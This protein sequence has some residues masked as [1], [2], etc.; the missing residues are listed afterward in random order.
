VR[1]D[2]GIDQDPQVAG[3]DHEPVDRQLE[4]AIGREEVRLEPA[5]V[6]SDG[7]GGRLGQ[8]AVERQ[9]RHHLRD[10]RDRH[11]ADRPAQ[12]RHWGSSR[13]RDARRVYMIDPVAQ[14]REIE[15]G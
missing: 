5:A 3:V 9:L 14:R 12:Q 10:A 6:S 8:E 13:A 4:L 15:S 11:V 1:P 2:A 7:R